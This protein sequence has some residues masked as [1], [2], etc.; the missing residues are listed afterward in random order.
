MVE[1]VSILDAI[2]SVVDLLGPLKEVVEVL[3]QDSKLL[4]EGIVL[5]ENGVD[6]LGV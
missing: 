3:S 4:L 1:E 2:N 5:L 6:C